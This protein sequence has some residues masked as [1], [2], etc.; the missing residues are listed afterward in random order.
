MRRI[1]FLNPRTDEAFTDTVASVIASG[2][3]TA[4]E[5]ETRL[6]D[7]YPAAVVRE[8][9]LA[10]E[11]GPAWY[12]YRDGHWIPDEGE[13]HASRSSAA[14]DDIRTTA[15]S[16]RAAADRLAAIEATKERVAP[17]DPRRVRLS[18]EATDLA[19]R[20]AVETNVE[21]MLAHQ[22]VDATD[23]R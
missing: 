6:R 23:D 1:R 14:Q 4:A 9:D 21:E 16:V 12:V 7:R 17:D 8:R 19:E 11:D 2:I 3:A 18:R 22:E 5:L 15:D 13:G 10:G 20:L